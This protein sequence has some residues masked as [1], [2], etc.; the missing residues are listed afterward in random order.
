[1]SIRLVMMASAAFLCTTPLMAQDANIDGRVKK[2]EKEVGALQKKVFQTTGDKYFE[3]EITTD[4]A[5]KPTTS[6][7]A[8]STVTDLLA[9]VDTLEAQM[10][11]L[12]GQLEQQQKSTSDLTARLNALEAQ[13]KNGAA[14]STADDPAPTKPAAAV[15]PPAAKPAASAT[16]K[17]AAAR[18]A[19]VAAIAKP[20]NGS[21]FDDGYDYGY[22]LWAAKFYP[23]AQSQLTE[24]VDKY[25][26]N[27]RISFAKNLLGR[28]Y[29]DD[30]QPAK[31]VKVLYANYKDDPKG[32]RAPESLFYTGWA[33]TDLD[34][35]PE[36]C[37][38]FKALATTYPAE[39]TGRLADRL[40]EGRARAKCK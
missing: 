22:R 38:A 33:L 18:L 15:K 10:T 19:A 20:S 5:S 12:T 23:E 32:A 39:A 11:T 29:L 9:R 8:N 14:A 35:A 31:A 6:T 37:G 34:K 2:L 1:M 13:V 30:G 24:I 7:G 17:A 27:A 25:P 36:A 3:P 26:K 28:A 21:G 40:K 4:Q 16:D